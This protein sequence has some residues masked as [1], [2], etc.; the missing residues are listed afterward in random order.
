M[1]ERDGAQEQPAARTSDRVRRRGLVAGLAALVAG[2]LAQAS[3][4]VAQAAGGTQGTA[5]VCGDANTS[6][7]ATELHRIG[8]DAGAPGALRIRWESAVYELK[9]ALEV[10]SDNAIGVFGRS[11]NNYGVR[12]FSQNN[13]GVVGTSN[14]HYGVYGAGQNGVGVF[15]TSLFGRSIGIY[16]R[17]VENAGVHGISGTSVGVYGISRA[18]VGVLATSA[19]DTDPALYAVPRGTGPAARFGGEVI[20]EG[21]VTVIGAATCTAVQ[22]RD[23]IHRRLYALASPESF[24]ED[25]GRASLADGRADVPLA[26]DFAALVGSDDYDVFLAPTGDCQ[27]LYV[28]EQRPDG[29]EVR[30]LQGGR[31]SPWFSYRVVAKRQDLAAPRLEPV[32][33]PPPPQPHVVGP[34]QP[35][36]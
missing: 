4:R 15:G 2:A 9:A 29:F 13:P 17:S 34:A 33:L 21:A 30:E 36:P 23:G 18:S 28:S 32:D 35:A 10:D 16:G 6:T 27:G 20:V 25:F 24:V 7:R 8:E 3:E 19:S 11:V 12:G 5:L 1:S 22:Q 31:S 26:P 14:N